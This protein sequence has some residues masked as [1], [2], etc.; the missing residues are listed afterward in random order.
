MV[1][2]ITLSARQI[3]QRFREIPDSDEA[4]SGASVLEFVLEQGAFYSPFATATILYENL[5]FIR[6]TLSL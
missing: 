1:A 3:N 2:L 6:K 5:F 4:K